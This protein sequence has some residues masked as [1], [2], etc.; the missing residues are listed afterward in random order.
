MGVFSLLDFF[1]KNIGELAAVAMCFFTTL[2]VL[3]WTSAG[4][5]IGVVALCFLRLT[6]ASLLLAVWERIFRGQWLPLDVGREAWIYLSISG[7]FGYFLCDFF[8]IKS[9][10]MLGPRL[11]L[12]IQASTPV[13]VSLI[14]FFWMGESLAILNALGMMVT[15]SGIAWVV[16]ERP[17][18][19]E[20]ILP[21]K[22]FILGL[23]VVVSSVIF[24]SLGVVFAKKGIQGIDAFA[25]TQIRILAGLL[26]YPFV[27]T[28]L[29]R[30]RQ[31]YRGMMHREAMIIL[32]L[33]TIVGPF[34]AM[35]LFMFALR[36]SHS[37][38]IVTTISC[39]SPI[40]ILPFCVWIY[41]EKVSLRAIL[42]A[43]IS[44]LGVVLMMVKSDP[45]PKPPQASE[46]SPPKAG[47]TFSPGLD[48]ANTRLFQRGKYVAVGRIVGDQCGPIGQAAIAPE[49]GFSEFGTVGDDVNAARRCGHFREQS[50]QLG[51]FLIDCAV[52]VDGVRAEKSDVGAKHFQIVFGNRARQVGRGCAEATA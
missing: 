2:S 17:D 23:V 1:H 38:G 27:V 30:W 33:G 32:A 6:A 44:F 26:C 20:N 43:G 25:A 29:W 52:C 39:L 21:R 4:R 28:A 31:V 34:L 5:R 7:V 41:K 19:Q 13:L 35:G 46:I 22:E 18:A 36:E 47:V 8:A 15:L 11:T 3:A 37:M 50:G 16:L 42:G 40:L 49:S 12:L 14:G 45:P 51:R 48:N 9:I 10:M 24:G